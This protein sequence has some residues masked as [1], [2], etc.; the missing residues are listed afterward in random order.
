MKAVRIIGL[1]IAI[2][3]LAPSPYSEGRQCG[4]EILAAETAKKA[5]TVR[6]LDPISTKWLE[7]RVYKARVF[8]K[9]GRCL[10]EIN[11]RASKPFEYY[12]K[13]RDNWVNLAWYKNIETHPRY[14]EFLPSVERRP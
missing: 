14:P 1:M 13:I 4:D 2:A 8:Y 12:V 5:G 11:G 3:M 7:M 9:E 10:F 6:R